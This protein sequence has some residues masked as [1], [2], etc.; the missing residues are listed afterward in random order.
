LTEFSNVSSILGIIGTITGIIALFISYWTFR[1]ERPRLTAKVL[2]CKHSYS[3]VEGKK[4]IN[5]FTTLEISNRGDR[6]TTINEVEV[7]FEIEG[8][9]YSIKKDYFR[10]QKV[11]SKRRWINPHEIIEVEPD[12]SKEFGMAETTKINSTFNIYHTHGSLKTKSV[13]EIYH[14]PK[15]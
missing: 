15:I 7:N 2:E 12:F 1:A 11:E 3:M 14:V 13:S 4:R 6:G 10:G 8:K 9:K 5:F